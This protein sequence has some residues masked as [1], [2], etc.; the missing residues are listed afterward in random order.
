MAKLTGS[1]QFLAAVSSFIMAFVYLSLMVIIFLFCHNAIEIKKDL[2]N[3]VWLHHTPLIEVK[4]LDR[5]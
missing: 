4:I 1:A 3:S 5:I 2:L